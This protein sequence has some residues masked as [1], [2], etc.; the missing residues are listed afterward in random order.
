VIP[1]SEAE[2]RSRERSALDRDEASRE[3]GIQ[4]PSKAESRSGGRSTLERDGTS[5]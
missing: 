1:L 5:P 3:G 2:T 4:P